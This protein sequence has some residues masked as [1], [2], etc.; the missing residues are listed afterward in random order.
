M[1]VEFEGDDGYIQALAKLGDNYGPISEKMLTAG[2]KY[3]LEQIKSATPKFASYFTI[4]K[5]KQNEYGWF[6]MIRMKKVKTSS[7]APVQLAANV[8][9]YG[10]K[11]YHQQIARPHVRATIKAAEQPVSE[12]MQQVYDEEARKI[13]GN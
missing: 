9:E 12:I 3:M 7:G 2:I 1:R 13:G 11:A 5:P 4:Q 8:Y 6:A 10:R